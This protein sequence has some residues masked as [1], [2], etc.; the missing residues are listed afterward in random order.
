MQVLTRKQ[1]EYKPFDD[2]RRR[3]YRRP[4]KLDSTQDIRETQKIQILCRSRQ[5]QINVSYTA[6]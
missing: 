5:V 1:T 2:N 4:P 3:A 6:K